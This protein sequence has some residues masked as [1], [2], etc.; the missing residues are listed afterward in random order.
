VLIERVCLTVVVV[1][2]V[3]VVLDVEVVVVLVDELEEELVE[4]P[5]EVLG[6]ALGKVEE[7]VSEEVPLVVMDELVAELVKGGEVSEEAE[8]ETS[9]AV[10]DATSWIASAVEVSTNGI[11][12]VNFSR[13]VV[14][15]SSSSPPGTSAVVEASLVGINLAVVDCFEDCCDFNIS[16]MNYLQKPELTFFNV[17][18]VGLLLETLVEFLAVPKHVFF[19]QHL[20]MCRCFCGR[21]RDIGRKILL[22]VKI[23]IELQT[24]F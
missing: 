9:N 5:E 22:P 2:V 21:R 4:A 16:L 14:S 8:V 3:V 19:P 11:L 13:M 6:K 10:V 24:R 12:L 23:A 15:S 1:V 17:D 18:L 20:M 7:I